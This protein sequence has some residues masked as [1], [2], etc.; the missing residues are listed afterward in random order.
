MAQLIMLHSQPITL[1][2][3][4]LMEMVLGL[5]FELN[6]NHLELVLQL[7][8]QEFVKEIGFLHLLLLQCFQLLLELVEFEVEVASFDLP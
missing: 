4:Y 2:L 6:F 3:L 1:A 7:H 5:P 8:R